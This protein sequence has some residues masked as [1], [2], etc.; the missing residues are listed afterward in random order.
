LN[1]PAYQKKENWGASETLYRLVRELAQPTIEVGDRDPKTCNILGPTA[2]GFRHR[3]DVTE[4]VRLVE[5]MGITI[6]VIAPDDATPADIQKAWRCGVQHRC[7]IRKSPRVPRAI[8]SK[9]LRQPSTKTVPIGLKRRADF[10]REVA[11]LAG[12]DADAAL[13]RVVTAVWRGIQ[14]ISRFHLSH[15][16]A[17]VYLW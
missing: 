5:A 11:G 15:R 12:L 7:S 2:L 9:S 16:Q 4:I 13:L 1:L 10:V 8:S 6:N 17:R 14:P 3:D